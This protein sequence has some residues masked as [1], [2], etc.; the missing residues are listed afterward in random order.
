[1]TRKIVGGVRY[2]TEKAT[3]VA[4]WCYGYPWEYLHSDETLYRT[5]SGRYFL[6]GKGGASSRWGEWICEDE[7]INGEDIEAMSPEEALAWLVD[8]ERDLPESCPEL[9]ALVIDA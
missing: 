4:S 2:D 9:A 5:T 7:W 8:H 3:E 6:H 1:M